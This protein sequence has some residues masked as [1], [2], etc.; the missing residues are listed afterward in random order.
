M[1]LSGRHRW[2]A[3]MFHESLT[4]LTLRD[5][6][7]TFGGL[8]LG[9]L[10]GIEL[11]N[12][13]PCLDIISLPRVAICLVFTCFKA[14]FLNASVPMPRLALLLAIVCVDVQTLGIARTLRRLTVRL[15]AS[16]EFH[17]T[18]CAIMGMIHS[19]GASKVRCNEKKQSSHYVF[20]SNRDRD[21]V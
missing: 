21:T 9:P 20:D 15:R 2:F 18:T 6:L 11:L 3:K 17:V 14:G 10:I 4:A 19:E 12:I 1:C 7:D 13:A 5:D 8:V 16:T